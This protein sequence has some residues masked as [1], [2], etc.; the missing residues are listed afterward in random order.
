[1]VDYGA[2]GKPVAVITV[3]ESGIHV[4]CHLCKTVDAMVVELE[5]F[6][7]GLYEHELFERSPKYLL[8]ESVYVCKSYDVHV[9]D[10]RL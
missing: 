6:V 7:I 9:S 10:F 5:M 8:A 3:S 2:V 1:M 4:G